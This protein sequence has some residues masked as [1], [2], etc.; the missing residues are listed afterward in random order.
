MATLL[1]WANKRGHKHT[2]ENMYFFH[3][4]LNARRFFFVFTTEI[5][6]QQK[7]EALKFQFTNGFELAY[8][9]Q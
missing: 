8:C 5:N 6:K 2:T 7:F 3:S 1:E 9:N 4:L